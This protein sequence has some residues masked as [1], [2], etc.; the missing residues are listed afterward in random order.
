MRR[1]I[2]SLR[3]TLH[4]EGLEGYL[5]SNGANMLYLTGFEGGSRLLIS[6]D[7]D[8][9][10]YVHRVNYDAAEDAAIEMLDF[11]PSDISFLAELALINEWNGDQAEAEE[12]YWDILVLDPENV[13]ANQ[14]FNSDEG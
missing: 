12:V 4:K 14:Y 11:Y 5:V 10:L 8:C 13:L 1:R 9:I 6:A 2:D 3:E 7:G